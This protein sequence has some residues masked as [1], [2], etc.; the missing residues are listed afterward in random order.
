MTPQSSRGG[1]ETRG[2]GGDAA[3]AREGRAARAAPR[4]AA[5]ARIVRDRRGALMVG[6]KRV[7]LNPR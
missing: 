7:A 4:H 6:V 5:A 3:P 1:Q 2:P